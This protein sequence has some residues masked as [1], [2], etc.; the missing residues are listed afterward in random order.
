MAAFL[1]RTLSLHPPS[2]PFPEDVDCSDFDT[3]EDA[4][5]WYQ[6][7]L[8]HYGDVAFLDEDLDLIACETLPGAPGT[9]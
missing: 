7:Y 9:G 5:Y 1:A 4:Q 6:W 2:P 3:W 8:P